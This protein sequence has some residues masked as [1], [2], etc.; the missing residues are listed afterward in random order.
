MPKSL[1]TLLLLGSALLLSLGAHADN[2]KGPKQ[3]RELHKASKMEEKELRK[4]ARESEKAAK[5]AMQEEKEREYD[6]DDSESDD[7][8]DDEREEMEERAEKVRDSEAKGRENA[9]GNVDNKG[10]RNEAMEK[11][12]GKPWWRFWGD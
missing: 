5:K 12:Q 8:D 11:S 9:P 10:K 1:R 6:D 2:H 7:A 4:A 3:D